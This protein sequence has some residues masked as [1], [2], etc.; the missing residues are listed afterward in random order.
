[1]RNKILLMMAG[2][3][4]MF[5]LVLFPVVHVMLAVTNFAA[6]ILILGLQLI[7]SCLPRKAFRPER[8]NEAE[9]F[10]SI[11]V[12]AHNEPP[13]I[14]HETLQALR[15][16]DWR[17]FEVLV[18]D[19]N[20][21]DE[22]V[23]KPIEELC[24][25]FGP[26]FRFFHVEGLNGAKAGAMN[27]ARQFV[28][29]R[30]EFI[31]VVDSDYVV[32]RDALRRAVGHCTEGIGLVQFPQEYRNIG[33]A[34]LGIALDFK[35]F[36]AGYMNMANWLGC[37]PS[38]GTLSLIRVS[39]LQ[40][41]NGFNTRVVTED[42]DLGLRLNAAGYRSIYAYEVVGRGLMPHDLEGL[43]MQRWRWAFG[44]AQI[45]KLNWRRLLWGRDLSFGQKVGY[46][47]HLTAWFNF[48]LIPSLTLILLAPLTLT[49][50]LHP[51]HPY[52]VVLSGFTITTFLV[53]RFGT[54]FF[55]LRKDRHSLP[56]IGLAFASHL[57]LGWIFSC[58]WMVCLM[59]H[60][61]PFVRTNK[62]LDAK[63]P[64]LL[65]TTLVE[66]TLGTGLLAACVALTITDFTIGPL[67]ALAMAIARFLVY[68]VWWQATKTMQLT[69]ALNSKRSR[70]CF[71]AE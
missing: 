5:L 19:N 54:L 43:K 63:V 29:Q 10:V 4:G 40:A 36:F 48:N 66:V 42:A 12:P 60:R 2:V 39:A 52:L 3:I 17:N 13:E 11:H 16:L 61:S 56:E 62:F 71:N 23:W 7:T 44:N 34:N 57:G 38:T 41:V 55:S 28:D 45:L 53:L 30:A 51:L 49:Q 47:V 50:F 9:P 64:S 35:H 20:T 1:M 65:R 15:Q 21:T 68:C 59:D 27:W 32:A 31:F 67:A 22:T 8:E 6:H 58:S 37:V 33:P 24:S 18:I 70:N 26:Q 69:A 14:L 46:L 25:K